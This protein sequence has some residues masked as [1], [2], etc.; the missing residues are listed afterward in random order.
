MEVLLIYYGS[1]ID[2][3]WIYDGSITGIAYET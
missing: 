1:I 2:L 3:L